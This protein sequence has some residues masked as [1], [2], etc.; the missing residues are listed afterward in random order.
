MASRAVGVRAYL[1]R[2]VLSL[3]TGC[4]IFCVGNPARAEEPA[5]DPLF[6]EQLAAGE[7]A[8]ARV[9][10][11]QAADAKQQDA[12]FAELAMAQAAVGAKRASLDSAGAIDDDLAR[13]D[14][15]AN[16]G[17]QTGFRQGGG[18]QPDFDSLIELITS[19]IAPT[20]WTEVGGAG[21]VQEFQSGVHIDA[22]GTV[23]RQLASADSDW[24]RDLRQKAKNETATAGSVRAT[25]GLRKISL[26]RLEREVQV[27]LAAGEP[28]EE[29]LA[30]LAGLQR[31][32]YVLVYPETGD[33]VLAGPAGN[34]QRDAE[35]RAVSTETGRPVVQLND[36]V[37]LLRAMRAAP[38]A[39]MTCSIDPRAENLAAAQEYINATSAKPLKAGARSAWLES[40]RDRVGLQ[41]VR[42]RGIDPRTRVAQ[43]LFEADYRMK[44]VG[45]GLEESVPGVV[46]Y[47]DSVKLA[48]GQTAPLMDVLRWWFTMNYSAVVADQ[49]GLAYELRGQ[50]VQVQSENEFLAANGQRQHTGQANDLNQAFANSFT[51]HFG[52]LAEKYPVYAELQNVF[53]LALV[54]AL[55]ETQHVPDRVGWHLTCFNNPQ[56]FSIPL[57]SA[58]QAVESV[59][60]HRVIKGKQ[61]IAAVSGGVRLDP[62]AALRN[63][64]P[65]KDTTGKLGSERDRV[66]RVSDQ[67]DRWWWD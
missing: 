47:L 58:P 35:G 44:L 1:P 50:G 13:S 54:A 62:Y 31:V 51:Q 15:M 3:I 67:P 14:T 26:T 23:H 45:I 64:P 43:V 24:L 29:D 49:E 65:Q 59:V 37:T 18:V 46:S 55:L 11:A 53:D 56:Q 38:D 4:G 63:T 20:T 34:W 40:I 30:F 25:S 48:P 16:L 21:A 17:N 32:K 12:R 6:A 61:I 60:N 33:I 39:A 42:F 10:A 27:R 22:A 2:G 9:A 41:D 66:R 19:T 7:F 57:A 8:P 28:I 52:E 5:A 36:L